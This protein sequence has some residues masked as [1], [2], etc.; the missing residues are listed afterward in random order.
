[1][2]QVIINGYK[3]KMGQAIAR[4]IQ[5]N[6]QLGLAL[7]G[8]REPGDGFDM[9]GDIIIDFSSPEGAQDAFNWAK[10]HKAACLIGTTN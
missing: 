3:G 6:T 1:M 8:G 2:K 10:L 4:I 9:Q 7:A 5:K